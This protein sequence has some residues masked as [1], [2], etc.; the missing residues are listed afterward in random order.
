MKLASYVLEGRASFGAIEDGK[1]FD[2]GRRS[3]ARCRFLSP[4][5]REHADE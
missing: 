4:A 1:V 5:P 2:L 3:G